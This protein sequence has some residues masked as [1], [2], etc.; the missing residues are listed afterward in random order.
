MW[1]SC[2][3]FPGSR[4]RGRFDLVRRCDAGWANK[5][6]SAAAI[7]GEWAHGI[8]Q[9]CGAVEFR[10]SA[11]VRSASVKEFGLENFS[12]QS[13]G[14]DEYEE[15]K[16]SDEGTA[17]HTPSVSPRISRCGTLLVSILHTARGVV[18]AGRES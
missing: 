5:A 11:T 13:I 8:A 15:T 10:A 1:W 4:G 6:V 17:A 18:F 9:P 14:D 2:K 12:A 3:N 7:G 16:K